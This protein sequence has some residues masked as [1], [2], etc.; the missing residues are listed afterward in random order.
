MT[1]TH[2]GDF[3]GIAPTGRS[4]N[5]PFADFLRFSGGKVV[6]HWGVTDGGTMLQQLGQIPAPTA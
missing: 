1:G 2:K 6:E 4:I 5:V 3:A